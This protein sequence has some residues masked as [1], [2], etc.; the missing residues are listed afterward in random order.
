M[1]LQKSVLFSHRYRY[2]LTHNSTIDVC[3][4]VLPDNEAEAFDEPCS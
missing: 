3:A 4:L 1:S 2:V